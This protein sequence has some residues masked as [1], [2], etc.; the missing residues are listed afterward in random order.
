MKKLGNQLSKFL[1]IAKLVHHLVQRWNVQPVRPVPAPQTV[2]KRAKSP[3]ISNSF[4]RLPDWQLLKFSKQVFEN[5]FHNPDFAA[6]HLTVLYLSPKI[7]R[8]MYGIYEKERNWDMASYQ[9]NRALLIT[10]LNELASLVKMKTMY[11]ENK[12][13]MII[14]ASFQ[15]KK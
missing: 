13:E 1:P 4:Q 6:E 15:V 11:A 9:K 10:H 14:N 3:I 5:M 12:E 7:K 8:M 2:K